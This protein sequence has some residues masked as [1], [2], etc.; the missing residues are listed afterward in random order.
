LDHGGAAQDV[1]A[2][3][4]LTAIDHVNAARP[5][6]TAQPMPISLEPPNQPEV[7]QL[8]EE[9]DAFQKLLYPPE[10]L[11]ALD[12]A[13]L[14]KSTVLFAVAR[15]DHGQAAACGAIVIQAAYGEVKRM[16][17]APA[18]RGQGL[19]RALLTFLEAQARNQ[20]CL[21]FALE[22]G[23]LQPEAIALYLQCG[24]RHCGPFGQYREDPNS[25]FMSKGGGP[26][27][28]HKDYSSPE[29][30]LCQGS[31]G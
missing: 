15:T 19:A 30:L 4:M 8:I 12:I 1:D 7:V 21:Q 17:T 31:A 10:S 22:T 25:V 23:Y 16:Y 28:D 24:F 26:H 6:Q 29:M 14:S 5:L 27:I 13:T 20:G 11:H 18:F 2:A 9:L 3:P